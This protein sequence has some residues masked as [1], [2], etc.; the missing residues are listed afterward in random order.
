[1]RGLHRRIQRLES[2]SIAKPRFFLVEN[3]VEAD[4]CLRWIK[5]NRPNWPTGSYY[6]IYDEMPP[7]EDYVRGPEPPWGWGNK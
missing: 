7:K 4:N 6:V 2:Q 3:K 5:E 1:M